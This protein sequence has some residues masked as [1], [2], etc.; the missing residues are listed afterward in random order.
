MIWLIYCALLHDIS[1]S[2]TGEEESSFHGHFLVSFGRLGK[3]DS[4]DAIAATYFAFTSLSTVGFGDLHP[5]SDAERL[6]CAFVLMM[7]VAIFS[8]VMSNF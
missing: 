4:Y 7:G 2:I 3:S 6:I 5:K 8:I 1:T